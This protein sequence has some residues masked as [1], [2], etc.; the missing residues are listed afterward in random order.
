M[1]ADEPTG[2]LDPVNAE[3]VLET[4]FELTNR[5]DATLLAVTHDHQILSRFRQTIDFADVHERGTAP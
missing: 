1:L 2:N 5:S 4:L 3:K